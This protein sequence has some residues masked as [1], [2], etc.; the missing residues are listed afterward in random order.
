MKLNI[1][2]LLLRV[3]T[4]LSALIPIVR[5]VTRFICCMWNGPLNLHRSLVCLVASGDELLARK[6]KCLINIIIGTSVVHASFT[7]VAD[8]KRCN[9]NLNKS[10]QLLKS[11]YQWTFIVFRLLI[12]M[13]S[14]MQTYPIVVSAL[15]ILNFSMFTPPCASVALT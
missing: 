14:E 6:R 13:F 1:F 10:L 8:S 9:E 5:L 2:G 12:L 11:S 3:Q 15:M 4:V 7:Y